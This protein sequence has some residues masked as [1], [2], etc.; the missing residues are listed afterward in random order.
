MQQNDE[1]RLFANAAAIVV[2]GFVA[3][4]VA[5]Q[6]PAGFL[7]GCI[8]AVFYFRKKDEERG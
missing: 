5:G 4:A 2:V 3:G 8:A 1:L 7:A 6:A